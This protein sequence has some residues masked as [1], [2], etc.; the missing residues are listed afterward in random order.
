MEARP[1]STAMMAAV[2]RGRHRLE[3]PP[4][5]VFDDALALEL[6]GPVWRDMAKRS[7]QL[8]EGLN[9]EIRAS[10]VVRSRYAEDQLARG[11]FAQYV[12]LGAGLDSFAWRRSAAHDPVSVF[13]VDHPSSQRWKRERIAELGLSAPDQHVFVAIDF[14]SQS[15]PDGLDSSGFD[16]TQP[17]LFSWLGVTMYLTDEA[18]ASTLRTVSTCVSGSQVVFE[19]SV[20]KSLLDDLGREFRE[21]FVPVAKDIGEALH[22]RWSPS[23][24]ELFVSECG[25]E[26]VDHP[27]RDDLVERYFA[28]RD[29]GLRPWSCSR[30]LTAQVP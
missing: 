3:D 7:S 20:P 22:S 5:W 14:E 6:V 18:V 26:T 12:M 2:A 13:E 19:Y 15:L 30:L 4:P 24:I 27:S 28:G 1:S 25:L 17:T 11:S 8:S 23:D 9:A 21:H 16:W 29:D 10:L